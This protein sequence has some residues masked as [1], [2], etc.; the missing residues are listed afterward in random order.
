MS[1]FDG[2][3]GRIPVCVGTGGK[4]LLEIREIANQKV[5]VF[6]KLFTCT[7]TSFIRNRTPKKYSNCI[8]SLLQLEYNAIC[9]GY[10]KLWDG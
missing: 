2:I 9:I 3:V 5:G 1:F 8:D 7:L 10:V 6:T 4:V